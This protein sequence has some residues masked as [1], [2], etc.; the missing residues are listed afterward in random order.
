MCSFKILR[1]VTFF[2]LIKIWPFSFHILLFIPKRLSRGGFV[3][4]QLCS[5]LSVITATYKDLSE[6]LSKSIFTHSSMALFIL[7]SSIPR[8]TGH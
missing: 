2:F 1:F 8:R 7:F 4:R 3:E 5:F 6:L